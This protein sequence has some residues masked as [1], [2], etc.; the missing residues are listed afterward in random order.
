MTLANSSGFPILPIGWRDIEA[1]MLSELWVL[2][3]ACGVSTDPGITQLILIPWPVYWPAATLVKCF[4]PALLTLYGNDRVNA[5]IAA[6]E[7]TLIIDPP[8]VLII[9]GIVA[10]IVKKLPFKLISIIIFH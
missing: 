1:S 5:S 10:F 9:C 8:P 7:A 4:N 6:E 3:L 2:P